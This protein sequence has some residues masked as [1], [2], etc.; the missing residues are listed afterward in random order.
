MHWLYEASVW[1][2]IV[3]AAVWLGGMVFVG[4]VVVPVSRKP[5]FQKSA[6][7]LVH[8]TGIQF[9]PVGW[10]CLGLIAFTGLFNLWY[11]GVRAEDLV[12]LNFWR[13][14]FSQALAYKLI[15]FYVILVISA[16]HD[17]YLGPKATASWMADPNSPKTAKYRNL[18]SKLGQIGLLISLAIVA[19]A[20]MMVRG[21]PW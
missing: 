4:A 13:M 18:A 19:F 6:A 15:L 9:R 16:V 20:V 1:L 21:L 5:D 17:F 11:R 3:A 7:S 2:H 8:H 10:I 14:P 12:S